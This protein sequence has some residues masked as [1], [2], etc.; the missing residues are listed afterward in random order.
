MSQLKERA[1]LYERKDRPTKIIEKLCF[2]NIGDILQKETKMNEAFI[3][4]QLARQYLVSGIR[5]SVTDSF[6]R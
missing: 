1:I 3:L 4:L 6:F 2:E 5:Q